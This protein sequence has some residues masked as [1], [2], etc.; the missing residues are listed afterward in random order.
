MNIENAESNKSQIYQAIGPTEE[1]VKLT[2]FHMM[3]EVKFVLTTTGESDGNKVDL[4]SSEGQYTTLELKNFYKDGRV[5]M[6]TGLVET[7]GSVTASETISNTLTSSIKECSYGV[8]PQDLTGV[9]VVITTADKNNY[10]V[11]MKDVLATTVSE[12]NIKNPYTADNTGETIKYKIDRW[13]P[14]FKYTYTFK[15]T[16]KGIE[17]KATVVDWEKVEA[18]DDEV[19]IQ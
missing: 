8:V 15:L 14:G 12:N 3:S 6:G 17:I 5:L 4:G 18:S 13:Y 7:T 19:Q 9:Q 10:I 1:T 16:K 11:N 2:L